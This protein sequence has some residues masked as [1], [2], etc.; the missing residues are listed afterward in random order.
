MFIFFSPHYIGL[1]SFMYTL[2]HIPYLSTEPVTQFQYTFIRRYK[3]LSIFKTESLLKVRLR[4]KFGDAEERAAFRSA[5]P[6][7]HPQHRKIKQIAVAEKFAWCVARCYAGLAP[8]SLLKVRLRCKAC[9][10]LR[11]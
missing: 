7:P 3:S 9:H 8:K 10:A 2:A 5:P 4:C 6:T 11:G 1:S